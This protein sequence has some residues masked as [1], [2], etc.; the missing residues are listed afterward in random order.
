[1]KKPE[2]QFDVQ[3]GSMLINDSINEWFESDEPTAED[4]DIDVEDVDDEDDDQDDTDI[5]DNDQEDVETTKPTKKVKEEVSG[6]D[7][8]DDS[9]DQYKDYSDISLVALALKQ[10]DPDLIPFEVKDIKKN[11]EPKELI[12]T[13]KQS[14]TKATEEQKQ[15]LEERYQGAAEYINYLIQG[16]D[17][18]VVKQGMKLKEISDIELDDDTDEKDLEDIVEA[19]LVQKGITDT[20]ERKDI[21]ELLKD[22]GKLYDRAQ[23]TID[24]FKKLEKQYIDQAL[25][26]KKLEKEQNDRMVAETKQKAQDI[27]NKGIVKGLPIRDK[28]KLYNAIYSPTETVEHITNEGKKVF[29]KDTLYNI[30]YQEFG[31]DLEQQIAFAQLLVDGFDFTKLVEV[32][33]KASNEE[34]LKVLDNRT[35]NK[36]DSKRAI[37]NGYLDL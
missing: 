6:D 36:R 18:E 26:Q 17:A 13:I 14:I 3:S 25:A 30:K 5:Q 33:K 7:D 19:G 2:A 1:M 31:R 37:Y 4:I 21:I 10:E 23:S 16:G 32:A 20:D 35:N 8:D 29:V 34:I 27:I 9:D 11:M 22:K 12:D 28:K 24:Q 15:V